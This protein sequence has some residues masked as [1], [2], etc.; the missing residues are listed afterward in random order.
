MC[1]E[2]I[3]LNVRS[4]SWPLW[5][6]DGSSHDCCLVRGMGNSLLTLFK[7]SSLHAQK[8]FNAR[9]TVAEKKSNSLSLRMLHMRDKR[10]NLQ[11][12]EIK[13]IEMKQK[14]RPAVPVL[15]ASLHCPYTN[16]LDSQLITGSA[17]RIAYGIF[18]YDGQMPLNINTCH[19][20]I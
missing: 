11:T 13:Q 15:M 9:H 16:M 18:L 19:A 17:W 2:F 5:Q 3:S 14:S 10:R 7:K 6:Q 12:E 1:K 20:S 4:V 8:T